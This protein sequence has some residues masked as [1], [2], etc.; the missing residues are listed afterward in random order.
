V[1]RYRGIN[2]FQPLAEK[3]EKIDGLLK[4]FGLPVPTPAR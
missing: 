1:V 2:P 3:T 4:E